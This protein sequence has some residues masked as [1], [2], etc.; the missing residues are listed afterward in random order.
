MIKRAGELSAEVFPNRFGGKGAVKVTRILEKDEFYGK[1]RVFAR[2]TIEPGSSLGYH[3]HNGDF[4][5]YYILRGHG[6]VNDNGQEVQV[7]PGDVVYTG[8]GQYHGIENTGD[9]TLEYIALVLFS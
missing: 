6:T 9:E 8:N 2:N 7:G 1:G 3:Q 4:E 5:V